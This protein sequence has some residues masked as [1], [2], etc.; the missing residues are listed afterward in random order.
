[1]NRKKTFKTHLN[2]AAFFILRGAELKYFEGDNPYRCKLVISINEDIL[3][4]IDRTKDLTVNYK[5]YMKVRS[6]L[7]KK[8]KRTY[9]L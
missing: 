7:K 8:I 2:K 6:K 9:K 5:K 1:M 3:A 4:E